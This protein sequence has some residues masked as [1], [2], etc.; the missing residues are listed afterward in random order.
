MNQETTK[1]GKLRSLANLLVCT[2]TEL[3]FTQLPSYTAKVDRFEQIIRNELEETQA[4]ETNHCETCKWWG[5]EAD[6]AK[7][8]RLRSCNHPK[9]LRGYMILEDNVPDDGWLSEDDEGWACKMGPKFGCV[10][11]ET[12]NANLRPRRALGDELA[13]GIRTS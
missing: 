9:A 13:N 10:N 5:D 11:H 2:S 8:L 12:V 4:A 7:G 3:P 1:P 6:R